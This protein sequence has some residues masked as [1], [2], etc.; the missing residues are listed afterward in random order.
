V[1]Q[2]SDAHGRKRISEVVYPIKTRDGAISKLRTKR[3]L[4]L[5]LRP[6]R[7]KRFYHQYYYLVHEGLVS[8]SLGAAF[9]RYEGRSELERLLEEIPGE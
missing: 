3:L 7:H 6:K 1:N 8:W 2:K 5:A 4:M 9:L